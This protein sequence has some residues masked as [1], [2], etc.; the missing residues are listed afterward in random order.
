MDYFLGQIQ[1]QQIHESAYIAPTA[2]IVGDVV[3]GPGT[4]VFPGAA[5]VGPAYIG[6]NVIIGNNALVRNSI[7]LDGANVGFTTEVAR[8]Y[9]DQ[10]C[11]M[12]ACRVLDSVFGPNVNFSAGCT[13]ANLRI[14]KGSVLSMVKG[15]RVD[16]GRS[17]LGAIIGEDAFLGVDAMTMP[18]AKSGVAAQVGPGA[19]SY[20]VVMD[21]QRVFVRQ[22]LL[23]SDD[24]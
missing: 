14:D 7:V 9:V 15:Q 3:I 6:G 16:S 17:N 13:T 21:R 20:R 18:G 2:S 4:K 5:V 12:H 23:V 8:S 22:Q 19:Q 10:G 11:Q 1:G 24:D